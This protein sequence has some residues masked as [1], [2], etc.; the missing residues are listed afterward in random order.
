MNLDK[1]I[2]KS[3]E[4]VSLVLYLAFLSIFIHLDT[5]K[6]FFERTSGIS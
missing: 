5:S 3:V 6:G 4:I 2:E 1:N